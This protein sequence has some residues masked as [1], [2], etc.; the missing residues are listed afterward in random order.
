MSRV[1]VWRAA[2]A[3]AGVLVLASCEEPPYYGP[4]GPD[5]STGYTDQQ[6]DQ[7]HFR[8]SYLGNSR[9][10]RTTVENFLLLR[11]AQVTLQAGYAGFMFDTRDT[12]TKTRYYWEFSGGWGGW[13]GRRWGGFY[14]WGPAFD[15]GYVEPETRYEAYA[16][17]VLLTDAE[18]RKE[19]RALNA[20]SVV[21]H[22]MPLVPVPAGP[23]PGPLP[24]A[25][26]APH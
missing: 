4:I 13:G 16:E 5:H 10:P 17:I 20:Q 3:A 9:T 15:E 8:I 1:R 19:P 2:A 7:R 14:H 6:I 25:A 26:P 23:P 12:K 21:D 11:S 22:L 18:A 24:A